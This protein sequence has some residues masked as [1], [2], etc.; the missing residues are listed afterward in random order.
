MNV[1]PV[2][3]GLDH[4]RVLA[5]RRH[6]AQLH[7]AVVRAQQHP[8]RLAGH[9]GLP[10]LPPVRAADR[11]V[12]Q[13][14]IA[15]RHA[16][17]GR[18]ELVKRRV[19]A[20]RG[21]VHL[22]RQR[23]HIGVLQ[24]RHLAVVQD[25]LDDRVRA[26]QRE[27]HLLIG[28]VLAGGRLLRLVQQ[29]QLVKEHLPELLR[30]VQ[31][32]G[33]ARALLDA[34]VQLARALFQSLADLPQHLHI[35]LHAGMLH[36]REHRQQRRLDLIKHL[37]RAHRRQLRA[38]LRRELPGHIRVLRRV[39][40]DLL[41]LA[42]RHVGHRRLG[43]E[44]V[45]LQPDERAQR[46][47]RVAQQALRQIVHAMPLLRLD[48]RVRQHRV[49]KRPRHLQPL[50]QQHGEVE[51][52][53]M[54][55]LLHT[56]L[57]ENRAELLQHRR[58][59]R[60]RAREK[61]EPPLMRLPGEGDAHDLRLARVQRGRLQVKA[62]ALQLR[63]LPDQSR[64]LL[65]RAHRVVGVRRVRQRARRVRGLLLDLGGGKQVV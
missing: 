62:E 59:L 17:R 50:R 24:L 18:H 61:H 1:Q 52:Q 51:L 48:E 63:E 55:R 7:L 36:A 46:H 56:R 3:E 14:R 19:D 53:V 43:K 40:G 60:R 32:E 10:Y 58:R 37:L 5:Q 57:G 4:R 8:A 23:V 65:R 44:I 21:A 54:P 16:P 2:L 30:A 28:L 39:V 41:R 9:K 35:H 12:L 15:R 27:Q 64:A 34:L 45:L 29:A 20:A 42:L 38:Q 31:V 33:H 47:R 6:H 11:D 22:V 26:G 25:V 49:K 13:V